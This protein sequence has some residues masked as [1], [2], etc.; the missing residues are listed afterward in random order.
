MKKIYISIFIIL[1]FSIKPLLSHVSH[2][3]KITFLKYGL[4]LNNKLIGNHVFNFKK[5]GDLFYVISK[6]SFKI[7]KLGV[8]LIDYI[9]ET[10]EVYKNDQLVKFNSNTKQNDKKKYAKVILNKK[11]MLYID[12]SSFQGE[13]EK[14][15]P[16]G[17]WWNHEIVKSSKQI[18]PISGRLNMQKVSF[19]GKKKLLINK[20]SYN[21][22]HFNFLSDDDKPINKKKINMDIWYDSSSLIWV[23]A[24]YDKLGHWEY[25]L[26]E[27]R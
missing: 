24:S 26:L 21:T 6:G 3:Q 13:T 14:N 19:L 5:E 23:K 1:L 7:D 18:S 9:T 2:Y 27:V 20:K 8:V 4:F 17:T 10:E 15:T 11:K 16:V 22:L 25:R 12:G